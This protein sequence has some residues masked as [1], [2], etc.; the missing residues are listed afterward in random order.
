LIFIYLY[1]ETAGIYLLQM[2]KPART[3]TFVELHVPDF[4]T[5]KDF[6]SKLGYKVVWEREPDEFKGYIVMKMGGS[7]LCFWAGNEYV[8]KHPY[9]KRFPEDTKRGYEVEIVVFVKNI[10]SYYKKVQKFANVVEKLILQPWGDKDFRVEDPFGFYLR[11]SEPYNTL[12]SEK[13]I[14]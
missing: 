6:Y 8:Y 2:T 11:F 13:A 9:F 3:D 14:K 12:F 5:V 1:L 4:P 7:I 10:E